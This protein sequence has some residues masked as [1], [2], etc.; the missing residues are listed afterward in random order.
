MLVGEV[1]GDCADGDAS[2]RDEDEGIGAIEGDTGPLVHGAHSL[3]V[4]PICQTGRCEDRDRIP[5]FAQ[6]R[7]DAFCHPTSVGCEATDL[8]QHECAPPFAYV[9]LAVAVREGCVVEKRRALRRRKGV[10]HEDYG[11]TL[12]VIG[13]SNRDQGVHGAAIDALVR[14][15]GTDD[16]GGR[17]LGVEASR[18]E[19][20][21][22]LVHQSCRQQYCH[23]RLV[24]CQIAQMLG[25]GHRGAS[26]GTGHD[27]GLRDTRVG[28]FDRQCRRGRKDRRDPGDHLIGETRL[29]ERTGHLGQGPE[30]RHVA[31]GQTHDIL[32]GYAGTNHHVRNLLQGHRG[33]VVDLDTLV[34]EFEQLGI[35]EGARIDHDVGLTQEPCASQG[36]QVRGTGPIVGKEDAA[37][38]KGILCPLPEPFFD[39][40]RDSHHGFLDETRSA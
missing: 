7:G 34:A 40:V 13:C 36:Y 23:R 24:L 11:R 18:Q 14:P 33:R 6:V 19:V 31:G 8:Y 21:L 27:Q 32:A 29:V 37:H 2:G 22:N 16:D 38:L 9:P 28:V 25:D 20:S 4:R 5:L 35:D 12:D 15:G 1:G 3:Y 30:D 10:S 17:G 26:L 39:A